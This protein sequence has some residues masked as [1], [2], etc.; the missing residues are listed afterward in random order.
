M[1]CFRRAF[2]ECSGSTPGVH[3][4]DDMRG[5]DRC[6]ITGCMPGLVDDCTCINCREAR[7]YQLEN[8][9]RGESFRVNRAAR[10]ST[11]G[12]GEPRRV[13]KLV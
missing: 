11:L 12:L 13:A 1:G 10:G 4:E 7:A 5:C 2:G 6:L 9:G 8:R 3:R